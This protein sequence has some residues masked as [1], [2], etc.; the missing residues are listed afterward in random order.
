LARGRWHRCAGM[1][2]RDPIGKNQALSADRARA[3]AATFRRLG[4]AIPIF[5]A[6]FGEDRSEVPTADNVAEPIDRRARTIVAVNP[7]DLGG[8][9]EL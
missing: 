4:V 8:W 1:R 2:R 9:Q 6:G 5:Y 3:L 7:P